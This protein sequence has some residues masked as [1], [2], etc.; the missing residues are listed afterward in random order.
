MVP[1][2]GEEGR[3]RM[4]VAIGCTGGHHRSVYIAEK[5]GEALRRHGYDVNVVHRDIG[6]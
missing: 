1:L 2:F 4:N 6:K 5:M 3:L